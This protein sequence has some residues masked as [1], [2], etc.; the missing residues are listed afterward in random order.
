MQYGNFGSAKPEATPPLQPGYEQIRINH[1][2]GVF[3][4][5]GSHIGKSLDVIILGL[6]RQR[7][8]WQGEAGSRRMACESVDYEIG[9]ARAN[10]F[11]YDAAGFDRRN[12]P[13]P[14]SGEIVKLKCEDCQ[15]R[16]WQEKAT[17]SGRTPPP[18][19]STWMLP[20]VLAPTPI[21]DRVDLLKLPFSKN[22]LT[23]SVKLMPVKF[24]SQRSLEKYLT[25][26]RDSKTAA[27]TVRTRIS[28]SRREKDGRRFSDAAFEQ[29]DKV[30]GATY[31]DLSE[32]LRTMREYLTEPPPLPAGGFTPM[33]M[34]G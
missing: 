12:Y 8:Y 11:D 27:Y 25:P 22:N 13:G 33:R 18:C 26:F 17:G 9:Y 28:L 2:R 34:G 32:A 20:I 14:P 23:K 24:S 7:E 1:D 31:P 30:G 21:E 29:L 19:S 5:H 3:T 10:T 16:K 15:L 6:V 4:N